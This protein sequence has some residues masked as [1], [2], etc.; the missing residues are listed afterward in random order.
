MTV[1]WQRRQRAVF[2]RRELLRQSSIGFGSLA[3]APPLGKEARADNALAPRP[4]LLAAKAKRVI[5][6]FIPGG[7]S[8]VDTFNYNPLLERDKGKPLPFA[9]PRFVSGETGT[10]LRSP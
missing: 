8:Q 9:K 4:P 10:L 5:F 1:F 3:R 7:P 6:L 2:T